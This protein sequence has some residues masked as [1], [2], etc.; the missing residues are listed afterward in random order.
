VQIKPFK[1]V[2]TAEA[3]I[4]GEGDKSLEYWRRAHQEYFEEECKAIAKSFQKICR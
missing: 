1:E 3:A 2:T 4:E